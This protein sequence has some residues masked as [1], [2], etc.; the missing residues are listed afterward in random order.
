M[1]MLS[2]TMLLLRTLSEVSCF[3]NH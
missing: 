2:Q 1:T 3:N